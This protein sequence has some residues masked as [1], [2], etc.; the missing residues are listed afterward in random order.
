MP[1]SLKKGPFVDGHLQKK[2]AELLHYLCVVARVDGLEQLVRFLEQVR[3]QRFV[4][5]FAIPRTSS[6]R[7]K[8]GNDLKNR[9]NARREGALRGVRH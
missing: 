1:R 7:A 8:P 9:G 6:R 3:P 5:L 2:V 4:C